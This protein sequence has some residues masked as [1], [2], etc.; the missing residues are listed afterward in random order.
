MITIRKVAR[1]LT[2]LQALPR[3]NAQILH[4]N[5]AIA[6]WCYDPN[7]RTMVSYD[8]PQVATQKVEYIKHMGLGG[9]MWWES[10]GDHS[11]NH[12]ESLIR[13]VVDGLGGF[14]ERHM[15]RREN[16]LEYPESKYDNLRKGMPGE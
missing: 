11:S 9:S 16:C 12:S 2:L 13:I 8:T 4:D 7:T 6:S 15:E 1:S 3:P 14:E 10:S 5:Q